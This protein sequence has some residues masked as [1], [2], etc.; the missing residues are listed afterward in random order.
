MFKYLAVTVVTTARPARPDE[1]V[2][3]RLAEVCHIDPPREHGLDVVE[4]IKAM[5]D[6]RM[7]VLVS[8]GGN[9]ALAAPDTPYTLEAFGNC[10][11]TVHVATKLN[12]SHIATE[13]LTNS[14]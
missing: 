5:H 13:A 12:R 8:L 6:G 2:L 10:D 3:T 4:T 14:T 1:Q 7:K 11:L 9:L